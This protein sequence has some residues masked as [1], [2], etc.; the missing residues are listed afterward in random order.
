MGEYNMNHKGT[1]TLETERLILRRFSI[2]DA[3]CMFKNWASSDEV[4][5]Y[6]TWP[7]HSDISITESVLNSWIPLLTSIHSFL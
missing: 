7:T 4:T 6:L 5:K 2:D 3:S 1:A